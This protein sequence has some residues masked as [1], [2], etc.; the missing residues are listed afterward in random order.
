M[1]TCGRWLSSGALDPDLTAG[2]GCKRRGR[3]NAAAGD[4][5]RQARRR[6]RSRV[7]V[8]ELKRG[9]HL[10]EA[11]EQAK[12]AGVEGAAE[13]R[14]RGRTTRRCGSRTPARS[15][16]QRGARGRRQATP[17]GS[18]PPCASSSVL[19]DGETT[20]TVRINGGGAGSSS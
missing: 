7:L 19:L 5:R 3:R 16:G 17:A 8:H 11:R 13:T 1:T 14:R 9:R 20:T 12:L 15:L 4:E 18:S 6:T 10:R 2:D